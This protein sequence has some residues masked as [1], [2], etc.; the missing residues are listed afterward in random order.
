MMDMVPVLPKPATMTLVL[1]LVGLSYFLVAPVA[2]A[3]ASAA[4][5]L[6]M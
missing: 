3:A 2:A 5:F 1:G 6:S 4:F